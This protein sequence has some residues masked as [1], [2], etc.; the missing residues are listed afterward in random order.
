[1][2]DEKHVLTLNYIA[3]N[4]RYFLP[5]IV[6][7][8]AVV[9][10]FPIG[11]NNFSKS[12]QNLQEIKKLET[13]TEGLS[14]RIARLE[15]LRAGE[16]A[17]MN[18]LVGNALSGKKPV[19]ESLRAITA[20]GEETEVSVNE[21]DT[22]PGTV[23]SASARLAESTLADSDETKLSQLDISLYLNGKV[24]AIYNYLTG[25]LSLTP[26]MD[27]N[28]VRISGSD[29]KSNSEV[30]LKVY[31]YPSVASEP[32]KVTSKTRLEELSSEQVDIIEQIQLL[33]SYEE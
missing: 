25:L 2:S 20:L 4:Y 21:L 12:I 15:E 8:I 3:T 28:T 27:L 6:S 31:W 24:D 23:A 17:S 22:S 7:V 32:L 1:M 19:F 13:E 10:L 30:D 18:D 9:F 26:L 5:T 11:I 29:V 14:V 33:K 16:L